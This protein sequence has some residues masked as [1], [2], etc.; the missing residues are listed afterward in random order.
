MITVAIDDGALQS[1]R[2]V[3]HKPVGLLFDFSAHLPQL[4][5]HGRDAVRLFD[6]QLAGVAHHRLAAGLRRCD[7]Q[8]GKLIDHAH[9]QRA[10]HL[11]ALQVTGADSQVDERFSPALTLILDVDPGAHSVQDIQQPRAGRI[12]AHVLDYNSGPRHNGAGH[13]QKRR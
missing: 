8:D 6:P 3:H 5:C 9:H 2:P 7:C 12:A 10:I 1:G 4:R 13:Q 11:G